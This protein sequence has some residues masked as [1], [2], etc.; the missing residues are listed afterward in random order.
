MRKALVIGVDDYPAPHELSGC[1]NDAL[2]MSNMLEKNGD[3]SPNF[4]VKTL[5]S[6]TQVITSELLADSIDQLFH[7]EAETAV[8]YF[9]GH[10]LISDQTNS[11]FLVSQDGR[12]P[13]WGYNISDLINKANG[14]N[15]QIQTTVIILDCCQSGFA[16]ENAAFHNENLSVLGKGLTILTASRSDEYAVEENGSGVFTDL[17]VDGL[18]G[19]ASDILG[20]VTPASLYSL[21]DQTLGGW[22]QRPIYKANVQKFVTLRQVPPKI[23]PELL[24]RLPEWFPTP[25]HR[26]PLDPSYE[27]DRQNIPVEF[28]DLPVDPHKTAV[29][30]DLQKMNRHGLVVPVDVEHMYDAAIQS[31]SCKLTGLGSHYRKLAELGRI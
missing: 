16:G 12:K 6:D 20:R 13:H 8:F 11:G 19:S 27:P 7:G 17:M 28:R 30:K 3:G 21:V 1:I 14:A 15:P 10:G 22:G 18:G 24:R 4:D 9:A 29:F 2:Q 23:A 31:T 5:T 26:F 25:T